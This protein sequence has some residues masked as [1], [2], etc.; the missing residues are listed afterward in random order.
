[1]LSVF[2]SQLVKYGNYV[3]NE[4]QVLIDELIPVFQEYYSMISSGKEKVKLQYRSHLS[5]GN[6][7]ENC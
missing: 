7:A 5:E 3:F 4:R 2:D 6:F 1:M